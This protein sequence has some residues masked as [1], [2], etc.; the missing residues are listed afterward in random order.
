MPQFSPHTIGTE[1]GNAEFFKFL[2]TVRQ[3]FRNRSPYGEQIGIYYSSSTQLMEMLPGGFRKHNDQKHSFAFY[4]WGTLLS[5]LHYDWKAIPQWKFTA[6]NLK[7]LKVLIIPHVSVFDRQQI[8]VLLS[9]AEQGG[10]LVITGDFAQR[11]D[12]ENLFAVAQPL[13]G[14]LSAPDTKKEIPLKQGRVIM[15]K[16][17][18]GYTFYQLDTQRTAMLPK[19]QLELTQLLRGHSLV[20]NAFDIPYTVGITL[21]E[22]ENGERLFID[23]NNTDIN[24]NEDKITATPEISFD[25][26]LPEPLKTKSVK[27]TVYSP[28]VPNVPPTVRT[29]KLPNGCLRVRVAPFDVYAGIVV[30]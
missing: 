14:I 30:E 13:D 2:E 25:V 9:W 6:E 5:G 16:D 11:Y 26:E 27:T 19:L 20:L 10:T 22:N 21:Y 3:V 17:C 24:I 1:E 23:L 12:E 15:L 29:E 28:N 8:P 18:P 4:G 7:P